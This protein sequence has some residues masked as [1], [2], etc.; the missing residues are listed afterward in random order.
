M[1][2]S[3]RLP[4]WYL[5]PRASDGREG[6][7]MGCSAS[8]K[9][10]PHPCH[11]GVQSRAGGGRTQHPGC[12]SWGW[13]PLRPCTPSCVPH[14]I[15]NSCHLLC[16]GLTLRKAPKPGSWEGVPC[17]P[18]SL[19]PWLISPFSLEGFWVAMLPRRTT[20]WGFVYCSN[21][22]SFSFQPANVD[23]PLLGR[24]KSPLL[25]S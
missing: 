16:C 20:T 14:A 12:L 9:A 21:L 23:S 18:S 15:H 7:G 3:S 4:P 22:S 2:V 5:S 8:S 6:H 10:V 19:S 1:Q 11:P 13:T 25:V 17:F 24:L